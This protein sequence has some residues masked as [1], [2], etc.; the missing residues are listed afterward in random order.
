M[1]S[2]P[3]HAMP[4]PSPPPSL[5]LLLLLQDLIRCFLVV[6]PKDRITARDALEHPWVLTPDSLLSS[7][8]LSYAVEELRRFNAKRR[9]R[10]GVGTVRELR[11]AV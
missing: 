6:D 4:F 5:L 10:A 7:R 1:P 2:Q 3:H 8:D 9:L 11:L